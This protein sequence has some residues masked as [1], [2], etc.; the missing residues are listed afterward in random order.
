MTLWIIAGLVALCL[1]AVGLVAYLAI[2]LDIE[3]VRLRQRLEGGRQF[4]PLEDIA[5]RL[6]ATRNLPTPATEAKASELTTGEAARADEAALV[7]E[8][9]TAPPEAEQTGAASAGDEASD[10]T[11]GEADVYT[12][13]WCMDEYFNRSSQP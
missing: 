2:A 8:T 12:L 6:A 7:E 11:G 1:L 9:G 3:H 13:A 4:P 10:E 5:G